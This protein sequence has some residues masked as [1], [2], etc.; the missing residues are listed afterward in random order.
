M[1]INRKLKAKKNQP[2]HIF[3]KCILKEIHIEKLKGLNSLSLKFNKNLTALMGVNGSGKSTILH[4][5]ACTYSKYVK[6]ENYKFSYFF[7]PNPDATW[8]DSCFT[9][10]NYDETEKKEIIKKYQKKKNRWANYVSRPTRDVHYIGV[11]SSIPQIE[12]EKTTSF[13][14]YTSNSE[15]DKSAE[16]VI[17]DASYILNKEYTELL[18]KVTIKVCRMIS[19]GNYV[20]N[21]AN[22]LRKNMSSKCMLEQMGFIRMNSCVETIRELSSVAVLPLRHWKQ[23]SLMQSM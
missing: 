9:V 19:A 7:T 10:I 5:L 14:N 18:V 16:K 11:A 1:P 12:V 3:P 20:L 23:Q 13:I 17:R 6:G 21:R 4:A 8:K 15:K 22:G 2:K